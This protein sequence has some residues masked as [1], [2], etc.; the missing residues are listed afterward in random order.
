MLTSVPLSADLVVVLALALVAALLL[1]IKVRSDRLRQRHDRIARKTRGQQRF[2]AGVRGAGEDLVAQV[3]WRPRPLM[4]R[5]EYRVYAELEALVGGSR[6]RHRLFAQV[7]LGAMFA[8]D[9]NDGVVDRRTETRAWHKANIKR[10]DFVIVDR[11]GMPVVGIEYQG[12]GHYQGN[13]AARDLVKREVFRLAGVPLLE[14]EAGGLT[15]GQRLDL[16]RRLGLPAALEVA[17]KGR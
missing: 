9:R 5:S 7:S 8:T 13:H 17:G 10:V 6:A 2:I 11:T 12:T 14:V 16:R 3:A 15:D 4:N 1:A